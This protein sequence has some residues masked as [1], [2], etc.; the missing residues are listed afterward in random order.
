MQVVFRRET[1]ITFNFV[2]AGLAKA[3]KLIQPPIT[4]FTLLANVYALVSRSVAYSLV[5]W[6]RSKKA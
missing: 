5:G 1:S 4:F 2:G 3:K 6:S